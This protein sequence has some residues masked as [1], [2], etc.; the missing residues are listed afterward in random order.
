V[1]KHHEVAAKKYMTVRDHCWSLPA[2]KQTP[3]DIE[4]SHIT[5]KGGVGQ[6]RA[7]LTGSS[8]TVALTLRRCTI[9]RRPKAPWS[10]TSTHL[11]GD[12]SGLK[13]SSRTAIAL[14]RFSTG[15]WGGGAGSCTTTSALGGVSCSNGAGVFCDSFTKSR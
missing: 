2:A 7:K 4:V 11:M 5:H 13:S 10:T 1:E 6:D 12:G 8:D 14:G 3:L 9:Q 15:D